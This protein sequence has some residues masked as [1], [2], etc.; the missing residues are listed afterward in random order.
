M[1]DAYERLTAARDMVRARIPDEPHVA[2]VLGSGLGGMAGEVEDAVRLP[3]SEIPGMPVPRVD[4]HSGTLVA[5]QLAGRRVMV[6]SGRSHYYEGHDIDDVVFGVR[7]ARLCGA[8][9]LFVT[10]AAGG[11]NTDLGPGDLMIIRDHINFMGINPLRGTNDERLGPRFPDMT[12][13]YEQPLRL[14]LREAA[15]LEGVQV[16]SGVYVGVAGPSYETPSE[17]RMLRKLG[18]DAVGMST[19]PEVIAARHMGMRIVGLSCIT[20]LAAGLGGAQIL[21]HEEVK[22]VGR[23]VA[24]DMRRLLLRFLEILP[25]AE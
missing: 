16:H 1:S 5:G 25:E 21:D 15:E 11:I 7:L 24:G 4:G 12:H 13:A 2:L 3:Y 20:N 19:V 8:K 22:G 6:F 23:R 10:N 17:I 14:L 9:I 18:A